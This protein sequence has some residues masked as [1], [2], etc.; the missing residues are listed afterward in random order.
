MSRITIPIQNMILTKIKNLPTKKLNPYPK[1]GFFSLEN[2]RSAVEITM[3]IQ[4]FV[5]KRCTTI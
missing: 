4:D 2:L 3:N 5:S 1:N